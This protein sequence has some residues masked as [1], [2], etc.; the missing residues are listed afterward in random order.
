MLWN[1]KENGGFT[2][3]ELLVVIAIIGILIALLLPAVQAAREAARRMQCTNNLKQLALAMHTY[4]AAHKA[5]PPG[6]LSIN[7]LSWNCFLLP[8]IE[9]GPLHKQFQEYGAFNQGTYNNGTNNEGQN[10]ANLLALNGVAGFLCPSSTDDMATHPSGTLTNPERKT[11]TSHYY[12]VSGPLG[13]N[14][15]TNAAYRAAQTSNQWGGFALQGMLQVNAST[16][17]RDVTDGTSNTLLLGE[18]ANGDGANWCRGVGL[19][20]NPTGNPLDGTGPMGMSSSKNVVNAINLPLTSVFNNIS[21]S[22]RHP[23][24][25]NFARADGS[26]DFLPDNVDLTLY[27]SLAT[28][29]GGEPVSTMQ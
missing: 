24:G 17:L 18:I 27:K 2:L 22:S 12:G 26:V 29:D 23:G 16:R 4:E 15:A 28:R 19:G 21:F 9:Q 11:Y 20:T 6:A 10:K 8:F 25:A 3:V 1:R 7:N 13:I 5:F 14:P